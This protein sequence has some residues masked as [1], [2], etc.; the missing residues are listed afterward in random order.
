MT[1]TAQLRWRLAAAFQVLGMAIRLGD[2]AKAEETC[3]II[4]DLCWRLDHEN[5]VHRPPADPFGLMSEVLLLV[6]Q[7]D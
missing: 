5:G 4:S 2:Y 6:E 7:D 3:E 1:D